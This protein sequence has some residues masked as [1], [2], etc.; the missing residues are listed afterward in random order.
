MG[1]EEIRCNTNAS[2]KSRQWRHAGSVSCGSVAYS[3]SPR[4]TTGGI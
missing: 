3:G 2:R 4:D 1:E